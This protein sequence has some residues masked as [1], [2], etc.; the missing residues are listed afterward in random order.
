M[1]T[2]D[3][4][5]L[6][7]S[8][9]GFDRLSQM[10]ENSLVSDQGTAYPPYNIVKLDD[11]NYRITMAV[12]GFGEKYIDITAKENQLFVTGKATPNGDVKK[13]AVYLHRGIAE[14]AF[15][16]RF[17]LAD[18]IRVAGA[19]LDN[20]LLTIDLLREIPEASKPRKITIAQAN[21]AKVLDQKKDDTQGEA[22]TSCGAC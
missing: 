6:F 13:G 16:R 7:R 5:P 14:R 17:Q 3:F 1:H 12:A 18:H 10:L 4:T 11:D 20:G 15:E 8:T 2:L 22:K 21:G 9:V 19:S